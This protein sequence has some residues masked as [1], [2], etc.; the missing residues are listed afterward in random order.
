MGQPTRPFPLGPGTRHLCIDLQ[1]LFA[2]ETPWQVPWLKTVLPAIEE[3]AGRHARQ[4]IFTRFVPPS[5]PAEA[6]GAWRDFY[7]AWP[8]MTRERLEPALLDLVPSLARLVPPARLLDKPANSA[9]S[10]TGLA[11][12]LRRRG[13]DTLIVTGGE[14]DVCVLATVMAAI[15]LGF[16][17]VLPTDAL[18]STRDGTHDALLKLYRER[19]GHQVEATT[20]SLVLERWR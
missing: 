19:F 20:S 10:R 16:R 18:C 9:F 4:T 5:T 3:I 14:T 15:D 17:I 6:L 1:R 12:A 11:A 8:N 13:V 7:G 2:E